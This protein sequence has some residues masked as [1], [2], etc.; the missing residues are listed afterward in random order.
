[1]RTIVRF[2]A[3][4][5]ATATIVV[6][7]LSFSAA[8]SRDAEPPPWPVTDEAVTDCWWINTM[9]DVDPSGCDHGSQAVVRSE[10]WALPSSV[11]VPAGTAFA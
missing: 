5:L 2:A 1:M 8:P 11:E 7:S 6:T 4:T 3:A 9:D 10:Q